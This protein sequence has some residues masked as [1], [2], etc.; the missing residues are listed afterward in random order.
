M[1]PSIYKTFSHTP[2]WEDVLPKDDLEVE[3][4]ILAKR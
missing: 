4:A 2:L 3:R 1:Q